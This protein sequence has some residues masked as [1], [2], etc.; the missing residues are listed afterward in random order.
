MKIH[1]ESLTFVQA[2]WNQ[3][4]TPS[5]GPDQPVGQRITID[6][7]GR[8][9]GATLSR[10]PDGTVAL[11]LEDAV[12]TPPS[13]L[14]IVLKTAQRV[15][16]DCEARYLR[17]LDTEGLSTNQ[18]AAFKSAG[19]LNS[20]AL[21]LLVW[22]EGSPVPDET[23]RRVCCFKPGRG[24]DK[25]RIPLV[26]TGPDKVAVCSTQVVELLREINAVTEDLSQLP[27]ATA[28]DL[29]STW[30]LLNLNVVLLIAMDEDCLN[31]LAVVS[32]SGS[33]AGSEMSLE[34]IGVRPTARRRG[35]AASLLRRIL[36]DL[37]P[38]TL[39]AFVDAG[40]RPAQSFYR[41]HAFERRRGFSLWCWRP[42]LP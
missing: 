1:S 31:G 3:L 24:T 2:G 6:D 13:V 20:A 15:A 42:D 12:A 34:F 11:T 4:W 18:Q 25:D 28:D 30:A 39:S 21:D 16:Q 10:I 7:R 26:P 14:S 29:L 9:H 36:L 22:S 17:F 37:Q 33:A 41:R 23:T 8:Q 32:W 35:I 38:G 27:R 19:F 5:R 40:N